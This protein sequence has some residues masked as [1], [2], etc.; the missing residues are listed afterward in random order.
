MRSIRKIQS[1]CTL[2]DLCHTNPE[3]LDKIFDGYVFDKVVRNDSLYQFTVY[4]PELR[5]VSRVVIKNDIMTEYN[6][7]AFKFKLYLFNNE[8]NFKKKIRLTLI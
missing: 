2:L 5:L 7:S 3:T 8:D 4:L 6:S 1:D